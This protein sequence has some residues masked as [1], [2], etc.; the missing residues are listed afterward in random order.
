M[1]KI[2]CLALVTSKLSHIS[3]CVVKEALT[4]I[5]D[6]E[7]LIA[8]QN[9]VFTNV[10]EFGRA[11]PIGGFDPYHLL[12]QSALVD[13]SHVG[14][15]QEGRGI[16]VDVDDGDMH[17]GTANK[18]QQN[19]LVNIDDIK[20]ELLSFFANQKTEIHWQFF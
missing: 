8:V 16:L 20:D 12:V 2:F 10:A 6:G 9:F 13:G 5:V 7:W 1:E 11:V 14:R 18:S 19:I 15:F 17:G 3:A 4:F